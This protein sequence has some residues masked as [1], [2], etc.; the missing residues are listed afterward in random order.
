[1]EYRVS[2]SDAQEK[3]QELLRLFGRLRPKGE[4]VQEAMPIRHYI[5]CN[6]HAAWKVPE[7]SRREKCK[8]DRQRG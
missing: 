4:L 3:E 5:D 2:E 6:F 1:M 8:Y 7:I